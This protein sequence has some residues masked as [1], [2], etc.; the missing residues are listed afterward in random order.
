MS[1]VPMPSRPLYQPEDD[2]DEPNEVCVLSIGSSFRYVI[3]SFEVLA[4]A[5]RQI[6]I[7]CELDGQL[8]LQVSVAVEDSVY[9]TWPSCEAST[10]FH[11]TDC[12]QSSLALKRSGV[13]VGFRM[14]LVSTKPDLMAYCKKDLK[15]TS[16][17]FPQD[18]TESMEKC[19]AKNS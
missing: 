1:F 18:K 3:P 16:T 15:I 8:C 14:A 10:L 6:R 4:V 12:L 13:G 5:L 7:R 2:D 19:I 11:A 17:G 9:H